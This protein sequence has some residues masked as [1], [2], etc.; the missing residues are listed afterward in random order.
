MVVAILRKLRTK[1]T[2]SPIAKNF[3]LSF[4]FLFGVAMVRASKQYKVFHPVESKEIS[5]FNSWLLAK[6]STKKF[7]CTAFIPNIERN[8]KLRKARKL[9]RGSKDRL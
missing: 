2:G 5:I 1:R 3:N 4:I 8:L 6:T 9:L 7:S